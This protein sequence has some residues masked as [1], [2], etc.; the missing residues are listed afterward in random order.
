[1]R[2]ALQRLPPRRPHKSSSMRLG[3]R[4]LQPPGECGLPWCHRQGAPCWLPDDLDQ[5]SEYLCA[6]HAY[7]AGYCKGCG[8][9]WGGVESFEFRTEYRG[10]CDNCAHQMEVEDERELRDVDWDDFDE[11]LP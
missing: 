9:F 8:Q 3:A 1:M 7:Q 4:S 11:D 5:P 2:A 6:E 10:F